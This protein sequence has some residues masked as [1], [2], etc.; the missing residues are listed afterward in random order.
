MWYILLFEYIDYFLYF[1]YTLCDKFIDD[2]ANGMLQTQPGCSAEET[3]E[4][5]GLYNYFVK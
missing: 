5:G 1:R 2:Y 4:V 3:V